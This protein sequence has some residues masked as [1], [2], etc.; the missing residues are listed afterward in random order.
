VAR[1]AASCFYACVSFLILTINEA[2]IVKNR[3][4]SP[5]AG[6][7]QSLKVL[8]D[9]LETPTQIRMRAL[10]LEWGGVILL[11]RKQLTV[12]VNVQE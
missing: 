2:E 1:D 4:K 3:A 12:G 6:A 7:D 11:L 10:S 9:I 8:P 5:C